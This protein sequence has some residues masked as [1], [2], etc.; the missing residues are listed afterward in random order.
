MTIDGH[1]GGVRIQMRRLDRGD[2]GPRAQGGGRHILPVA[3]AI[4]TPPHE[5]VIGA[6]P[7]ESIIERRWADRV[8]DATAR[9]GVLVVLDGARIEV[10][11]RCGILA[12]QIRA[13][14]VPVPAVIRG[15][16]YPLVAE[17]ERVSAGFAEHEWQGPGGAVQPRVH[18]GRNDALRLSRAQI[19]LVNAAAENH[20]GVVR[21][22]SDIVVFASGG[23]FAELPEIDAVDVIG[24]AGDSR[25]A[26]VL[27]GPVDPCK[28]NGCP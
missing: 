1:V 15:A 22:R 27:L 14:C 12:A 17:I 11:G 9:A 20:L 6:C 2:L 28:E 26:G 3:A 5:P 4:S 19:E 8:D 21:V 25:R 10:C 18:Q 24:A 23:D 13:D 7:D 16:K